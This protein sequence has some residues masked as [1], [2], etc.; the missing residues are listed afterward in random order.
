VGMVS[1]REGAAKTLL[2]IDRR[3]KTK[4]HKI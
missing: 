4:T 3:T 2:K 1:Y